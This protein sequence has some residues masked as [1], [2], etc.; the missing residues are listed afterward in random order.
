MLLQNPDMPIFVLSE[1][2]HNTGMFKK[3]QIGRL[4]QSSHFVQQLKQK[5]PNVQPLQFVM[6]MLGMI[7][8]PFLSKPV[9][10]SAGILNEQD[11]TDIMEERRKLLPI[12]INAMLTVK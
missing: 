2:R 12:W 7:I 4:F 8:F 11:F 5:Q 9:F 6:S 3:M 1:I 10:K